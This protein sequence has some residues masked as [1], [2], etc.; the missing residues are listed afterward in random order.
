MNRKR[1]LI[2]CITTTLLIGIVGASIPFVGSLYP[3]AEKTK[4][5]EVDLSELIP[6]SSLEFEL[7]GFPI[8]IRNKVNQTSKWSII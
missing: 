1:F 4:N 8:I 7:S 3:S 6:G 5:M 2:I